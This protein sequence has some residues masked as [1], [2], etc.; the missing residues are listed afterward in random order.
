[1]SLAGTFNKLSVV[2]VRFPAMIFHKSSESVLIFLVFPVFLLGSPKVMAKELAD[3]KKMITE[4]TRKIKVFENQLAKGGETQ[5]LADLLFS[6]SE[7]HQQKATLMYNKKK[8]ENPDTP[9]DELD[10]T[11]EDREKEKSI[12]I[13]EQIVKVFPGKKGVADKALYVAALTKKSLGKPK[14][15]VVY[16]KKI[17]SDFKSGEYEGRAYLELGDFYTLKGDHEFAIDF[18]KK[19]INKKDTV[20]YYRLKNK[21]GQAHLHLEK[22]GIAFLTFYN[23][24]KE[25]HKEKKK[26]LHEQAAEDLL[27]SL[28][29]SYADLL[30]EEMKKVMPTQVPLDQLLRQ[31]S[32]GERPYSKA[33][34]VATKRF[35]IKKRNSEAAVCGAK[36]LN[37]E[38]NMK[39]RIEAMY[40]TFGA[41]KASGQKIYLGQFIEDVVSTRQFLRDE[42]F[43]S[44]KER[45]KTE[46]D[47]EVILRTYLTR[48]DKIYRKQGDEKIIVNLIESYRLF[49]DNFKRSKKIREMNLNL[50]ELLFS[51][52]DYTEAG[53]TYYQVA[54]YKKKDKRSRLEMLDAAVKSFISG[55][56]Q[57]SYKTRLEKLEAQLGLRRAGLAYLKLSPRGSTAETVAFNYAQSFYRERDFKKAS[58]TFW[59]FLRRYPNAPQNSQVALLLLDCFDQMNQKK[60]LISM[61][62]KLIANNMVQS[63][64]TR[65]QVQ[66]IVEETIISRS[67][68]GGGAGRNN[69]LLKLASKYKGTNLGDKALYEA[70]VDMK[71]KRDPKVYKVGEQLLSHHK[72]S[73]FAKTVVSDM[74]KMAIITADLKKAANY[75]SLFAQS[76][77]SDKDSRGFLNN[78]ANIYRNLHAF[79]AAKD[80][81][82][83]LG[84]PGKAAEMDMLKGDWSALKQSCVK[85]GGASQAFYCGVAWYFSGNFQKA[86]GFL[87]KGVNSGDREKAA[88]SLYFLSLIK[89]KTYENLKMQAGREVETIQRKQGSLVELQSLTAKLMKTGHSQWGLAG[90]F[91]M[92][93][94][95]SDFNRFILSTPM[96]DRLPASDKKQL[97]TQ[98]KQQ[99]KPYA[100]SSREFFSNCRK[101]AEKMN[102]FNGAALGCSN[103]KSQFSEETLVTLN[104]GGSEE[105]ESG[106]IRSI[107]SKLYDKP[108]N[109]NLYIQLGSALLK[110][111]AGGKAASV[112]NRARDI[113]SK[114]AKVMALLGVARVVLGDEQAAFE[115]FS[116]ARQLNKN[117]PDAIVGQYYLFKKFKYQK[118]LRK[119]SSV[120]KTQ[121]GRAKFKLGFY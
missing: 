111:K 59:T 71:A 86:Q 49:R 96:P 9:D 3:V 62:K 54:R 77:P 21:I 68:S 40:K 66:E 70:F 117:E 4:E 118:S 39:D 119:I 18:Y 72:D 34:K 75:F 42:D 58:K 55:I 100:Q 31:L 105:R 5:L 93:R 10:F 88:G 23:S 80:V 121:S 45:K 14:E 104:S 67:R 103:N 6:L 16:L 56:G 114:N 11:I 73:Q 26:E 90:Q 65:S 98:L 13:L 112:L 44:K 83:R 84:Q 60:R 79:K 94:T 76:Y 110:E 120:Y 47:M 12:D 82:V 35:I 30:K 102:V 19:G 48:M 2:V 36:W 106:K 28:A 32:P 22:E 116:K 46:K 61:G 92:G 108:R 52:R 89:L 51:L 53:K 1:M 20:S 15:A 113:D 37:T 43:S 27:Q 38:P 33:L 81:F 85:A 7:S 63:S 57:S 95:H 74:A 25:L 91:L 24:L 50:A 69:N 99:A 29:R 17:V 41:W 97:Q 101:N 8:L 87:S 109:I 64:E 115:S 107:R 78:A